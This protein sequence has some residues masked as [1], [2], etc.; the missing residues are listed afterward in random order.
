MTP[1]DQSIREAAVKDFTHNLV[2]EASAGTGKTTLLVE[3]AL[4][5]LTAVGIDIRQLV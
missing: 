4:Y 3:R 1:A 5:A 2:V